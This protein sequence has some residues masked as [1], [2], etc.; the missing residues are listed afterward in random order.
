[1]PI[2]EYEC[3]GCARTIEALQGVNEPETRTCG[4][5]GGELERIVSAPR[6]NTRNFSGPAEARLSRTSFSEEIAREKV[7]QR[8]YETLRFPPGV[9]HDPT[10]R[11]E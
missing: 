1:V 4:N 2:Y 8:S 5:C 11:H 6:L 3:R 7:L 10:E 9:K